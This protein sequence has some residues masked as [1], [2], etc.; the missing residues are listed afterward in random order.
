MPLEKP[1]TDA[2]T[3][4]QLIPGHTTFASKKG[5]YGVWPG[6]SQRAAAAVHRDSGVGWS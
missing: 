2:C 3:G 6:I 1:L 5:L 4:Q